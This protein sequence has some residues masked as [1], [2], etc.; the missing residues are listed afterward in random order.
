[1]LTT[2]L[3]CAINHIYFIHFGINIKFFFISR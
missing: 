3:M 1:M 2:L